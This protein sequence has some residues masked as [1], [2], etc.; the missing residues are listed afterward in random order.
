MKRLSND[1]NAFRISDDKPEAQIAHETQKSV[2]E[3]LRSESSPGSNTIKQNGNRIIPFSEFM[4]EKTKFGYN[5][6]SKI[7]IPSAVLTRGNKSPLRKEEMPFSRSPKAG[8]QNLNFSEKGSPLQRSKKELNSALPH[9]PKAGKYFQSLK[10]KFSPSGEQGKTIK[11]PKTVELGT[12]KRATRQPNQ[13]NYYHQKYQEE[14]SSFDDQAI[15]RQETSKKSIMKVAGNLKK[16]LKHN[17][18]LSD[19]SKNVN[20]LTEQNEESYSSQNEYSPP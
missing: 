4:K 7:P 10:N 1:K 12:K 3:D 11:S 2:K 8:K 18:D 19:E 6:P 5:A 13:Q 16:K 20:L 9:N 14:P 15:K 17:F